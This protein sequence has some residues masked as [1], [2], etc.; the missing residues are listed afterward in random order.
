MKIVFEMRN[1][2]QQYN[3]FDPN[4]AVP[5]WPHVC[6]SYNFSFGITNFSCLQKSGETYYD[7]FSKDYAN[8]CIKDYIFSC[9]TTWF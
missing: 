4:Y 2:L 7:I 1:C 6:Y 9:A 5:K 3:D 8:Q